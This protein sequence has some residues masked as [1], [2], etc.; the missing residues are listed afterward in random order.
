ML[1]TYL[2][3]NLLISQFKD[4]NSHIIVAIL[5]KI[6]HYWNFSDQIL[7]ADRCY[8]NTN[9]LRFMKFCSLVTYLW[10]NLLI[11]N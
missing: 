2:W 11:L 6:M 9:L 7:Y 1:V 8:S 10:P 5:P 3:L 4:N